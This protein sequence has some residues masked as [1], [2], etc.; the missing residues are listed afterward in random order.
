MARQFK[1]VNNKKEKN[2]HEDTLAHDGNALAGRGGGEVEGH[3][4][5]AQDLQEGVQPL[6]DY[7]LFAVVVRRVV[8]QDRVHK[9]RESY[10]KI[11]YIKKKN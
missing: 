2:T 3:V 8:A 10:F 4:G 7:E 9:L 11:H 1:S 6:L 5:E